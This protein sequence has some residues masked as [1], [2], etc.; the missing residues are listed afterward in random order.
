MVKSFEKRGNSV[1]HVGPIQTS[2][3]AKTIKLGIRLINGVKYFTPPEFAKFHPLYLDEMAAQVHK[4]A[5]ERGVDVLLS[6]DTT[7]MSHL[8][9][10]LPTVLWRDATFEDLRRVYGKQMSERCTEWAHAHERTA[11]RNA[12][13]NLFSSECSVETA[14]DF[15]DIP[16]RKVF[17]VPFG[18]NHDFMPDAERMER[19]I[20]RKRSRN[21]CR[22][23][24]IGVDWKRKGGDKAV[25]V[26]RELNAKG[27]SATLDVIGAEWSVDNDIK[28]RV[29][30]HGFLDKSSKEELQ[31]YRNLL[32]RSHFL[33]H[34]A[35]AEAY[36][37]VLPEA[38]SFGVP[39]VASDVGGIP[40]TVK[41]GIT[42][43]T[44]PTSASAQEYAQYIFEVFTNRDRYVSLAR[45]SIN[46]FLER[47]NWTVAV[48]KVER[49]IEDVIKK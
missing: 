16:E 19:N 48:E 6:N 33:I 47:H 44:F 32:Q 13:L 20:I 21:I 43:Q 27:I 4:Q 18:A 37:C 35:R 25:E 9:M 14:I 36:G 5:S 42:G 24:F 2:W 28:D 22:L 15:Y 17:L 23:I 8:S 40:T 45:N 39:C 12:D 29:E 38:C 10:E 31:K 46:R 3:K 1:K 34:P 7:I 11:M 49:L 26:C 30:M 41:P